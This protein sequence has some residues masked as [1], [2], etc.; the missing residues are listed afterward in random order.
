VVCGHTERK[1]ASLLC[2]FALPLD[3][4]EVML[5]FHKFATSLPSDYAAASPA[6]TSNDKF[7]K[8]YWLRETAKTPNHRGWWSAFLLALACCL[9]VLTSSASGALPAT[10]PAVDTFSGSGVLSANWTNTTSAGQGY[11]PLAQSSGTVAPSVSGQQG[12]ATYTGISF[13]NDQY[14][15][16][17]FVTHSTAAGST[18]N[19]VCYLADWGLLYSLAN[20]AGTY[21]ITSGCPI[22]ASGDTIQLLVVGTIYTCTDVTTGASK[23]VSDATYSTGNP[24]ILV[25]Q[26]QSTVYALAQFQAD[27]SPSCGGGSSPT[28]TPPPPTPTP[29]P[30]PTSKYPAVDTFSGSGALSA[31][32][33]NTTS[34]DQGYVPLA[35]SA[36]T[37]A[38]SVSG[39]QGLATYTGIS[40]TNDQYAQAKF[41]THST[42]AGS[43]GVC[44]RMNAAGNGV[45]YLADW[46]LLYSLANGAGT[47]A[48]T[49]GCPIPASGNTIQL[50]VVGTTYT[51]TDVTTGAS[52]SVSDATYSTG[53]PAILVDQRQST[54]YA[55]AQFQADCSPSC[56][57]SSP[58]PTPTYSSQLTVTPTSLSFGS[59]IVKSAATQS[60]TLTSTGT[61]PVTVNSV[62]ITG[63]GFTIVGGS[64]P[65]TLTPN[66]SMTLQVQFE[67]SAAGLA[68]GELTISSNSTTGA[69]A[70]VSLSGTGTAVAHEVDLF[71]NAPSSS[72]DPIAGYNVYRSIGS[73]AA[74]LINLSI[75]TQ[76]AYVD[77]AVVSG[78]TYSYMVKSVDNKGV[79]SVPSNQITVTIP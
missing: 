64:F 38:P 63:A 73:G 40:F 78:T 62:S 19:G 17:K 33:T 30:T 39:Q 72:P 69:P 67:P 15:Q 54:V 2:L 28:P 4:E 56:G 9:P 74:K 51:C 45:C 27:C 41:V 3:H 52:R 47:Y 11:V 37:I 50:L 25:D 79:E 61:L 76:T 75:D 23:S 18:G 32:W 53:N 48:I 55:L 46:G 42:A 1:V 8:P 13:T 7:Q 24:A 5:V 14:A 21:A 29:T 43:T 77:S 6:D 66:Q 22:P 16:A 31:N 58:T 70:V 26:R 34:A 71:W 10:Y 59:V 68:T 44:V 35:Q 57:G 49:S 20:G 60:L 36:G 12:L 65:V